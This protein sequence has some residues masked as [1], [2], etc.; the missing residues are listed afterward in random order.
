MVTILFE[1]LKSWNKFSNLKRDE[2][3]TDA[4][5]GTK[6]FV[7]KCFVRK[8]ATLLHNAFKTLF[9]LLKLH[10]YVL[11]LKYPQH[12]IWIKGTAMAEVPKW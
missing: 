8:I 4:E 7:R 12:M 5:G 1:K 6:I 11:I 2:S 10:P 3:E 9:S